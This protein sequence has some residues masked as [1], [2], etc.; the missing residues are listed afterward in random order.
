MHFEQKFERKMVEHKKFIPKQ[1]YTKVKQQILEKIK[2]IE[3][4]KTPK[5]IEFIKKSLKNH[6]VFFRFSD[7]DL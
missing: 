2:I 3:K 4:K 7:S 1:S 6:F 5:D